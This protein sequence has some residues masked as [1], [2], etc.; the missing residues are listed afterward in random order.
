MFEPGVAGDGGIAG[1]IATSTF[2]PGG[3]F[4]I[5]GS[6]AG[7]RTPREALRQQAVRAYQGD[8]LLKCVAGRLAR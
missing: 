6:A 4:S 1:F 2:K 5:R 8:V 3:G 7:R